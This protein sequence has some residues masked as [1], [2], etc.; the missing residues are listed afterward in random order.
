MWRLHIDTEYYIWTVL[1]SLIVW[2][3]YLNMM[4]IFMYRLLYKIVD[5]YVVYRCISAY[6]CCTHCTMLPA[7]YTI[8][9]QYTSL[10]IAIH[11]QHYTAYTLY[12]AIHSPSAQTRGNGRARGSETGHGAPVHNTDRQGDRRGLGHAAFGRQFH[13]CSSPQD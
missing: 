9:I 8:P 3:V 2:T 5:V 10:Y 4:Y 1:K 12:I 11:I 13:T 6:T 7:E